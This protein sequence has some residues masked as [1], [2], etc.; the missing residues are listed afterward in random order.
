MAVKTFLSD[1]PRRRICEETIFSL[2]ALNPRE[3]SGIWPARSAGK[4]MRIMAARNVFFMTAVS[5][6]PENDLRNIKL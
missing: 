1:I 2:G 5:L 4:S 3:S 6:E